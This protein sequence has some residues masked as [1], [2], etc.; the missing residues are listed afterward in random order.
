[1]MQSKTCKNNFAQTPKFVLYFQI[2]LS[3]TKLAMNSSSSRVDIPFQ[4]TFPILPTQLPKLRKCFIAIIELY[5][6]DE[7]MHR[8]CANIFKFV[9]EDVQIDDTEP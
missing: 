7:E 4:Y 5:F 3:F 2:V 6:S 9:A 8:I 1:M